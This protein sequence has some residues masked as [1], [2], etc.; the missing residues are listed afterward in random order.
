DL[1]KALQY[2]Y[3]NKRYSQLVFYLEACESGSMFS[4]LLP[5]NINVYATTASN[6]TESSYACYFD[7]K[8][9]TYLGDVY[10]VNWIEDS[11]R[12]DWGKETLLDQFNL[13][14][15]ETNTS[16]VMEYG[17]FKIASEG[18]GEFQGDKKPSIDVL[19]GDEV[20]VVFDAVDSGDVPLHIH[21]KKLEAAR[22]ETEKQI[23]TEQ[24]QRLVDGREFAT[25]HFHQ[26]VN[27]IKHLVG[28]Q[29]DT[30]LTQKQELNNRECY[31][32]LVD[33]FHEKC[34]NLNENPFV[35]RKLYIFA[36]VCEEL[37]RGSD[38]EIKTEDAVDHLVEYC[39]HN[40]AKGYQQPIL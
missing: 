40:L 34:L 22:D 10:S 27:S 5:K 6:P 29:I 1:N 30:I 12:K 7:D 23:L 3:D 32:Q 15:K 31:Q 39:F 13:V 20:P 19:G 37:S 33:T 11:D 24:L 18:L 17:D 25:K 28:E 35:L 38:V 14:K 8:R 9:Q 4:K 36:N 21:Q 26:Y 2:M 16:H